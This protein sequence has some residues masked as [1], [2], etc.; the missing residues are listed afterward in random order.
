MLQLRMRRK[1]SPGAAVFG[2]RND[3]GGAGWRRMETFLNSEE[4]TGRLQLP[5]PFGHGG[6]PRQPKWHF[7]D[8]AHHRTRSARNMSS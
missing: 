6:E 1:A 5:P 3:D 8:G 4:T 2:A 7:G